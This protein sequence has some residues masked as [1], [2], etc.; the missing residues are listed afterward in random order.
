MHRA[1]K[2]FGIELLK[3]PP[4]QRMKTCG[5]VLKESTRRLRLIAAVALSMSSPWMGVCLDWIS[6]LAR[7]GSVRFNLF[8]PSPKVGASLLWMESSTHRCLRDAATHSRVSLR[9]IS[10][11]LFGR[12]FAHCWFLRE[13]VQESGAEAV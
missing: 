9:W 12:S 7:P 11:I 2:W 3:Q 13:E 4:S 10:V 5:S 1:E 8:R 6:A